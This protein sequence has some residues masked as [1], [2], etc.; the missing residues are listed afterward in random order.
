ML[1]DGHL[2]ARM[3]EIQEYIRTDERHLAYLKD[4]YT[5]YWTELSRREVKNV[6]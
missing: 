6:H 3:E 4:E 5:R 2:K 1:P